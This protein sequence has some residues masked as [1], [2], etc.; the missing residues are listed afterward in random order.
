VG[1]IVMELYQQALAAVS[2]P[3]TDGRFSSIIWLQQ[4][5]VLSQSRQ[6][7]ATPWTVP[8]QA[9]L[10]MEAKIL[11]WVAIS[12]SRGSFQ[13]RDQTRISCIGKRILYNQQK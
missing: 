13:P 7:F 4:N 12:C 3:L 11:E 2:M 1:I 10:S 8:C 5:C 6:L 9:P